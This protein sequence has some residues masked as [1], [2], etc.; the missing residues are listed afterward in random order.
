MAYQVLVPCV[1]AGTPD[2]QFAYYYQDSNWYIAWLSD[3][4][5]ARFLAAGDVVEIPDWPAPP[6]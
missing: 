1:V 3:A 6:T 5:R 2:G 4:D